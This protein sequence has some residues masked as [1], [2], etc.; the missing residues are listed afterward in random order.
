MTS[1]E[2]QEMLFG[3]LKKCTDELREEQ[4]LESVVAALMSM[5]AFLAL[6]VLKIGV[7]M[8]RRVFEGLT[9]VHLEQKDNE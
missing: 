9:E 8:F 7:P 2:D 4:P 6:D 5:T 3:K 1:Y